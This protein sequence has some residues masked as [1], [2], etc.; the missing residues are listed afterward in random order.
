MVFGSF[1]VAMAE[2]PA[3]GAHEAEGLKAWRT[4]RQGECPDVVF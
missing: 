3:M 1:P 4:R 2:C